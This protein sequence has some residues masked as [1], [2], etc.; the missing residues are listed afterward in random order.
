MKPI[1]YGRQDIQQSDINAVIDVLNSEFL[2]QGPKVEEF[3]NAF[4]KYIGCKYAIAVS[5]GTAAL[6]LNTIALGV[7]KGDK[8]ITTPLTF[9]ASANCVKYCGGDVIFSDIDPKSYLIDLNKVRSLLESSPKGTYKGIITVDFAGRAVDLESLKKLVSEYGL[10]IIQDSCHS[11]GGFFI[12]SKNLKQNCGNG[13]FADLAI[14]SFHPVK[15]IATGEGGMITTNNKNLYDKLLSLRTHG[16]IK[17]PKLFKNSIKISGGTDEYPNWYME[18]QE[19]G[20]NYR[21]TDFQSALGISQLRRA[22]SNIDRRREI[23]KIYFNSFKNKKFILGQSGFVEGHA[24]HLYILEVKDR[25]AL[26]NYLRTKNIY[27]QIHYIPLHLMPFYRNLG[28]SENDFPFAENFYK[29]CISL[30]CIHL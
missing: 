30:Q 2:T 9:A 17:K 13:S 3:E 1:P 25:L 26:Y 24:Y 4:S 29:N 19:L 16:I 14:F 12:D 20:Y 23:A 10:W 8:V 18:M 7:K 11:P 28:W 5:N 21:L 27:T 6:H 22:K 15:H